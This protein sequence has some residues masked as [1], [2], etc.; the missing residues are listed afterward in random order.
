MEVA[1][2]IQA[3]HSEAG[4]VLRNCKSNRSSVANQINL[5]ST[6]D[7]NEMNMNLSTKLNFGHVL[8]YERGQVCLQSQ[9]VESR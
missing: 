6:A 4:Y 7:V 9:Y 5:E 2:Q 1:H 8:G 3:I